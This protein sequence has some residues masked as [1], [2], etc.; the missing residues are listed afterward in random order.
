MILKTDDLWEWVEEQDWLDGNIIDLGGGQTPIGV[1]N[2]V[3]DV[4]R[5]PG[6]RANYIDADLNN[7]N[8]MDEGHFDEK[9][10]VAWCNHL[11][12]DIRWPGP[13]LCD[14]HRITNKLIL[15]TP[16]FT[17]EL[18]TVWHDKPGWE[19]TQAG[20]PHH[21]WLI[22]INRETGLLEAY[23]KMSWI[24]RD[25]SFPNVRRNLN[26]IFEGDA[27]RDLIITDITR[28]YP[29]QMLRADLAKWLMDRWETA[30]LEEL[31]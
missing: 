3:V 29:N 7:I 12:E 1:A 31:S 22:G 18:E 5:P 14:I 6:W 16:H 27:L 28:L 20:F 10:D 4:K 25:D 17:R 23:A 21:K 11:I 2:T 13:L 8:W 9:F 30:T 19:S 24:V 15:G 26:M